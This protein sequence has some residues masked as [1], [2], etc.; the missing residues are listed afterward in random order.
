MYEQIDDAIQKRGGGCVLLLWASDQSSK[1]CPFHTHTY[2]LWQ[3]SCDWIE[4]YI[5][6]CNSLETCVLFGQKP[7]KHPTGRLI[8]RYH[9]DAQARL[10][11][12][13]SA[14][15]CQRNTRAD[16]LTNFVKLVLSSTVC[17]VARNSTRGWSLS[18]CMRVQNVNICIL[19]KWK[20]WPNSSQTLRV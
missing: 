5:Y 14:D 12:T 6:C 10:T 11:N 3:H 18:V 2:K 16:R 9:T 15:K 20:S 4:S 8:N 1:L 13:V 19:W 17:R 7:S